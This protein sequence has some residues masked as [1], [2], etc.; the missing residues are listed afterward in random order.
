MS[1][2]SS[3]TSSPS[4]SLA[5]RL[6]RPLLAAA[7]LIGV[8]GCQL[9][10]QTA[11]REPAASSDYARTSALVAKTARGACFTPD[12]MIAVRRSVS[13]EMRVG[14]PLRRQ[15]PPRQPT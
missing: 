7:V 13:W 3:P 14:S 12:E 5:S 2:A 1:L 8:S 9:G 6:V 4:K 15:P 10:G 11:V